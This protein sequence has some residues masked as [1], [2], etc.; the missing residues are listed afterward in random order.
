MPNETVEELAASARDRGG[1]RWALASE[2]IWHDY[3]VPPDVAG[4]VHSFVAVAETYPACIVISDM[5]IPGN[6][7]FFINQEFARVTGYSKQEAQ[8]R[9]CRF[10]QS[11]QTDP[12]A[13]S[14]IRRGVGDGRPGLRA[15]EARRREVAARRTGG[16]ARAH[17]RRRPRDRVLF[18][19][20]PRVL[21]RRRQWEE[22]E[23]R[24]RTRTTSRSSCARSRLT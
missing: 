9:N 10:L 15:V 24:V 12:V 11:D 5:A 1:G 3:T 13:V 6:P 7:M 18:S 14:A 21:P 8:G 2:L 20:P 4:W 16:G 19:F 22:T 17:G 23:P